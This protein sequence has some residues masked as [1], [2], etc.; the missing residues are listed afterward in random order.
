MNPDINWQWDDVSNNSN[1]DLDFIKK[2]LDKDWN[3]S[4]L[5]S[6][7]AITMDDIRSNPDMNWI[8]RRVPY[9]PN[10]DLEFIKNQGDEYISHLLDLSH[11][12]WD[13]ISHYRHYDW[14]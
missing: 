13:I 5:S 1:I 8:N 3:W 7:E 10:I 6:H 12:M 9:N 14:D 4:I 2:H 11:V